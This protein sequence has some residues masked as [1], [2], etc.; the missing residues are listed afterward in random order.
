M[1]KFDK[2]KFYK[3]LKTLPL[4]VAH[5]V[6][7]EPQKPPYLIYQD[8]DFS[9]LAANSQN[10]HMTTHIQLELYTDGKTTDSTEDVVETLLNDITTYGKS[11][12]Y[13]DGERVYVTYYNFNL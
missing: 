2:V 12:S 5:T 10:V 4:P 3:T 7:V 6:F 8:E 13:I 9:V 11:R 1:D